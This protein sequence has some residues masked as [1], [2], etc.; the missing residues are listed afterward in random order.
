[1]AHFSPSPIR[2]LL[3]GVSLPFK[4]LLLDTWYP[5]IRVKSGWHDNALSRSL[6]RLNK[7]W[8][9]L[10]LRLTLKRAVHKSS[11]LH[12][13]N[14]VQCS[15]LFE[16]D[17]ASVLLFMVHAMRRRKDG[18]K[19]TAYRPGGYAARKNTMPSPCLTQ[20]I[21][22]NWEDNHLEI[23][24]RFTHLRDSSSLSLVRKGKSEP[25]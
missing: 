20:G 16:L 9:R 8:A 1:M 15:S 17:W 23:S 10:I 6:T 2:E 21:N 11:S 13:I 22:W 7:V 3:N 24:V 19:R 5:E 4:A 12:F 18:V 14:W 25:V